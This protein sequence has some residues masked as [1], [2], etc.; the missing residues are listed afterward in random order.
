[1]TPPP[2]PKTTDQRQASGIAE[3]VIERLETLGG[4]ELAAEGRELLVPPVDWVSLLAWNRRA[5]DWLV[6][7]QRRR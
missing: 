2:G 1:M 6:E 5:C 4:M 3:A 7:R